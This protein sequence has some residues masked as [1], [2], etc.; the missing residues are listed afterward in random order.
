MQGIGDWDSYTIEEAKGGLDENMAPDCIKSPKCEALGAWLTAHQPS[1]TPGDARE[2][3]RWADPEHPS[4]G[5][6]YS[7]IG[8]RQNE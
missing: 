7:S 5:E 1:E 6:R 2:N 4:D 3:H 8:R